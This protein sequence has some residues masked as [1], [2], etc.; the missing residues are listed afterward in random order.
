MLNESVDF[1]KK[2]KKRG[3]IFKVDFEKAY[4]SVVWE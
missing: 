4:D 1:M 2:E 3:L